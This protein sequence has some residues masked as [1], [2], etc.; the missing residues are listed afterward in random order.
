[1]VVSESKS[2]NQRL[3]R[4]EV[5]SPLSTRGEVLS[6][7]LPA[8]GINTPVSIQVYDLYFLKGQI[9]AEA[10]QEIAQRLIC[11]PVTEQFTYIL[12]DSDT[13]GSSI[14]VDTNVHVIEVGFLPGVTD[15]VANELLRAI[16]R[17][18]N[19]GVEAVATG[20]RYELKGRL[21]Q[22]E[23]EQ[24]A[25]AFPMGYF[26]QQLLYELKTADS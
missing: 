23:V 4:I 10:P 9:S 24:I 17:L 8:I 1:M 3:C 14:S 22:T 19:G 21:S 12:S 16:E 11:D 20:E 18:G 13:I 15:N 2:T 5:T 26:P 7:Q 6:S 25:E